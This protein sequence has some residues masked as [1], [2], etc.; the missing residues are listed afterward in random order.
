MLKKRK[1]PRKLRR[2]ELKVGNVTLVFKEP[3]KFVFKASEEEPPYFT[4]LPFS[5]DIEFDPAH[6]DITQHRGLVYA[7]TGR[8]LEEIFEEQERIEAR[9]E[10]FRRMYDFWIRGKL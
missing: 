9:A 7:A 3:L 10:A 4:Y 2:I 6:F 5:K 1:H 8:R